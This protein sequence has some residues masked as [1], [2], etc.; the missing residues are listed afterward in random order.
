M[1]IKYDVINKHSLAQE[2][3]MLAQVHHATSAATDADGNRLST[4]ADTLPGVSKHL[5]G[6]LIGRKVTQY[7]V[8][9]ELGLSVAQLAPAAC[10]CGDGYSRRQKSW[11]PL[12]VPA[13]G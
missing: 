13:R 2:S 8:W 7:I 5:A 10:L 4:P 12:I 11:M 6:K 9:A 3:E 1:D